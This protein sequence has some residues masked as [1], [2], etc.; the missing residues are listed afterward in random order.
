[1]EGWQIENQ[2][3]NLHGSSVGVAVMLLMYLLDLPSS[4]YLLLA[5]IVF[6]V[7]FWVRQFRLRRRWGFRAVRTPRDIWREALCQG[8]NSYVLLLPVFCVCLMYIGYYCAGQS[9]LLLSLGPSMVC[10]VLVLL[11]ER[12]PIAE[13]V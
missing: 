7:F 13:Y 6:A 9:G 8:E 12:Y 5:S 3:K 10:I 4:A 1:M 2:K 11:A